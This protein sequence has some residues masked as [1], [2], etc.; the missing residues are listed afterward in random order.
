ML[1][2]TSA[3]VTDAQSGSGTITTNDGKGGDQEEEEEEVDGL[4]A[5]MSKL[6]V[7]REK[8]KKREREKELA[9]EAA[10]EAAKKLRVYYNVPIEEKDDFKKVGGRWD[11]ETKLWYL[12][13]AKKASTMKIIDA[14]WDRK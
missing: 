10:K 1:E 14:M 11:P 9:K 7:A 4:V 12:P 6:K 2:P 3:D 8:A 5:M 13:E